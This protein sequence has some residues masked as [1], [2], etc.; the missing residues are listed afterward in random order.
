MNERAAKK[1]RPGPP[2][3][4]GD[5]IQSC[6]IVDSRRQEE[7]QDE[8]LQMVYGDERKDLPAFKLKQLP[9]P[10]PVSL[11][12]KHLRELRS[13]AYWVAEKTDG[14]RYMLFIDHSAAY[15]VNRK[16]TCHMLPRSDLLASLASHGP[17][18]L[19]GEL[20]QTTIGWVYLIYDL[21]QSQGIRYADM[22]LPK[23]LEGIREKVMAP[24]RY[25]QRQAEEKGETLPF[26]LIGKTILPSS[27][28]GDTLKKIQPS[29][30][31]YVYAEHRSFGS[32]SYK[33]D[34]LI[35]MAADS[36]FLPNFEGALLK[37][38]WP[39]LNSIDFKVIHPFFDRSNNLQLYCG[40]RAG[41]ERY[42]D[43]LCRSIPI[44][45]ATKNWLLQ[46]IESLPSQDRRGPD[47]AVVEC[48]YD[49]ENSEWKVKKIRPDKATANFI[50][51]VIQTLESIID[52]ITIEDLK[53]S[54]CH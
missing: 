12:R 23:R 38:K 18:L 1:S 17:T 30:E 43:M 8:I 25:G 48:A 45:E 33:N 54:C 32:I 34:G 4:G 22:P 9:G 29:H 47:S 15:F 21:V 3:T 35:F 31:G 13:R 37:W 36:P 44:S 41:N 24:Y 19:D 16:F 52:N 42:T 10:L 5:V 50:T 39:E 40:A 2:Q 51:T 53:Q 7:V 46:S 28:I 26:T 49:P 14:E 27:K 20:V 11:G 6:T